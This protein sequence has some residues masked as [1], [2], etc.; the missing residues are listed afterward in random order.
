[1]I[2]AALRWAALAA[3]LASPAWAAE[4][5]LSCRAVIKHTAAPLNSCIGTKTVRI[6]AVGDV[7]LHSPLQR[8]G[9]GDGDGFRGIWRVMEPFFRAADIAYAN[10]EGPVAPGIT[11]GFGRTTD[12]GPVFDNRVYSSYPMFNYHPRVVSDLQASGINLVSTANNHS[13]DRGS[14]GADRTIDVLRKA[15]LEF[16]GTIKAGEL[17][18]FVTITKSPLGRIAWIACSYS[19]NGIGDPNNQVLMCYQNRAELLAL[20][21]AYAAHTNIAAVIVTPHWGYEYQHNPNANQRRLAREMVAAGATAVIG[22]HPHVVQP[23]D[24]MPAPDGSRSLVIYSTG[25]FV[26]GQTSLARR[27]GAMAWIELCRAPPSRDLGSALRSGLVVARAGWV[28]VVMGR[29]ARG[30]ELFVATPQSEGILANAYNLAARYLPDTG[31]T[32]QLVCQRTSG[33]PQIALQ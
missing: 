4:G 11:R 18:K 20:I 29:T 12:P 32:T 5:A 28:P 27:T 6:T 10:L 22:T 13:L 3:A 25:N 23:W 31:T 2:R 26:S 7:L 30:P 24:F 33:G 14:V 1:M 9:Y 15:G 17:R 8:R 21:R 19:T 16:M